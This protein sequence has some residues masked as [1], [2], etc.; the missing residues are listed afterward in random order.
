[1]ASQRNGTI[2]VGS[3]VD[4]A[5]RAWEHRTGIVEGFTKRHGCRLLVWYEVHETLWSARVREQRVKDWKRAWKLRLIEEANPLWN[6]LTAT[7]LPL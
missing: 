6:D 1:M 5:K 7:L 4:M 3:T 2:Y